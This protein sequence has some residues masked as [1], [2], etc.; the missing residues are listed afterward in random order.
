[1]FQ[2]FG[3]AK[4][5]VSYLWCL[6]SHARVLESE[7]LNVCFSAGIEE[8][9]MRMKQDVNALLPPPSRV[10]PVVPSNLTAKL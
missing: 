3:H 9:A 1:M 8:E 5:H 10:A 2:G 6:G 7:V 4:G